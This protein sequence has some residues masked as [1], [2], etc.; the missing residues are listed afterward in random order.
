MA[1]KKKEC[2]EVGELIEHQFHSTVS[3]EHG[4]IETRRY[5]TMGNTE[6]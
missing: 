4:W 5:W 2:V 1:A 3:Q 6:Y